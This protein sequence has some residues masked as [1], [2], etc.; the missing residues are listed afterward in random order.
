[1]N[2]GECGQANLS[3]NSW[4]WVYDRRTIGVIPQARCRCERQTR[5]ILEVRRIN[6]S[7]PVIIQVHWKRDYVLSKLWLVTN[8]LIWKTAMNK[9]LKLDK[10]AKI[11]DVKTYRLAAIYKAQYRLQ[12]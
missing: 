12:S 11:D 9:G 6:P 5:T 2:T 10:I 3:R 8:T 4:W 1:V 7:F